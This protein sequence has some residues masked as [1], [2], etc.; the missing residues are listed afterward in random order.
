MP[1]DIDNQPIEA[2][3][4]GEGNWLT[5]W[6]TPKAL[7]IEVLAD[8]LAGEI[9][10]LEDRI[11]AYHHYV[12]SLPYKPFIAGR[13]WI[14]GRSSVQRDLWM[15]PSLTARVGIGN[16]ANKSFLLASLIRQD[17][18]PDQVW[19]VLGNLHNGKTGG[20]AWVEVNI[21]GH[22]FIVEATRADINTFVPTFSTDAYEAVHYF[23]DENLKAIEGRT[24]L[25]P[26]TKCYS[27]WLR[28]YLDWAYIEGRGSK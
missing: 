3:F 13:L 21:G 11:R 2:S 24:V 10:V 6:V 17:L 7:E 16:C 26:F 18:K 8:N 19:C 1:V 15:K 20:H 28:D 12:G 23:N 14:E 9:G 25:E 4:F 27:T 22:E 5:D